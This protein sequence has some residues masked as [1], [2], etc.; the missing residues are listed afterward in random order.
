MTEA[1]SMQEA[2]GED[3]DE[4]YYDE[5]NDEMIEV[6]LPAKFYFDH[7]ER[8]LPSGRL[9]KSNSRYAYVRL[10][11]AILEEIESDARYQYRMNST[12]EGYDDPDYNMAWAA[13][14]MIDAIKAITTERGKA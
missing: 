9:L 11:W 10:N 7:E 2:I 1:L 4:S 12:I 13:K 8:D 14:R 5:A 6:R 3:L